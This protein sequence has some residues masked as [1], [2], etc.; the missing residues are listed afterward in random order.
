MNGSAT[1]AGHQFGDRVRTYV[2]GGLRR[3]TIMADGG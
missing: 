2:Q 3:S 1:A